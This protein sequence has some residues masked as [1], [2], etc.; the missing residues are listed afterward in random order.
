[1]NQSIKYISGIAVFLLAVFSNGYAQKV[2]TLEDCREQAV[3][4]NKEL[5]TLPYKTAKHR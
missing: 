2:M 3:A 5:K 1:M 4:F